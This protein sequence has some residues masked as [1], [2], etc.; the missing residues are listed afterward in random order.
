MPN[1]IKESGTIIIVLIAWDIVRIFIQ[2]W[3]NKKFLEKD[4]KRKEE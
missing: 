2:A 3:V 1:W 4:L